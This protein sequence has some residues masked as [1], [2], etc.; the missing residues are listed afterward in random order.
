MSYQFISISN[1][2]GRN[3]GCCI[4]EAEEVDVRTY[5]LDGILDGKEAFEAQDMELNR[6]YTKQEMMDKGHQID[7]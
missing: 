6:F 4:V 2:E 1:L 3:L 5:T 7:D